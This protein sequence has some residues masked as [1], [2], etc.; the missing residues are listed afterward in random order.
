MNN[1]NIISGAP[2][3]IGSMEP[4]PA[5]VHDFV[6]GND[7][8]VRGEPAVVVR[9]DYPHVHWQWA[10]DIEAAAQ[11]DDGWEAPE[12]HRS[13]TATPHLFT[14][15]A[16]YKRAQVDPPPFSDEEDTSDEEDED[17]QRRR[18]AA[19]ER[20]DDSG[21]KQQANGGAEQAEDNADKEDDSSKDSDAPA[22][23]A[24]AAGA[25]ASLM[26]MFARR[27][28]KA[29]FS[30]LNDAS[31]E[32]VL[33][34]RAPNSASLEHCARTRFS[35]PNKISQLTLMD[36]EDVDVTFF[37]VISSVELIRCRRCTLRC[38]HTAR[39]FSIDDSEGCSIL[40]PGRQ[41]RV[42]FVSTNS[43]RNVLTAQPATSDAQAEAAASDAANDAADSDEK[44]ADID[45]E[46]R[47]VIEPPMTERS[48]EDTEAPVPSEPQLQVNG[49][50]AAAASEEAAVPAAG[51]AAPALVTKQHQTVWENGA[52]A[53][54]ELARQGALGY[55]AN[56]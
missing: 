26:S 43:A 44:Q 19:A 13:C 54:T 29:V 53:T 33:S 55:F 35:I 4:V 28:E 22:D 8:F 5:D 15:P 9:F 10:K 30:G 27:P 39:T 38:L 50:E 51:A 2:P 42:L 14:V 23:A 17:E 7:I 18:A 32:E 25:R 49:G 12:K 46:V 45:R 1:P 34:T 16:A 20:R 41:Q 3:P 21:D 24:A 52:F 11:R 31:G 48:A 37:G 56:N 47:Y 36:C 6:P 40:F